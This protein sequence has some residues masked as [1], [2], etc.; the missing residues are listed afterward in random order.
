MPVCITT[1]GRK[2][3]NRSAPAIVM[4]LTQVSGHNIAARTTPV[5][6]CST[7]ARSGAKAVEEA[8]APGRRERW[9]LHSRRRRTRRTRSP[10]GRRGVASDLL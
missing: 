5:R 8:S 2:S 7:C 3:R 9:R 4:T 1:A 10:C 6:R